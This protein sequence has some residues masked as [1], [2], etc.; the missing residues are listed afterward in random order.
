MHD[1]RETDI[2]SLQVAS[3][4]ASGCL[5]CAPLSSK[6]FELSGIGHKCI[7]LLILGELSPQELTALQTAVHESLAA[8]PLPVP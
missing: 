4:D 8:P 7:T 3:Q 2:L 5:S 1:M 6:C